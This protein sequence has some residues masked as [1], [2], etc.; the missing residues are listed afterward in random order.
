MGHQVLKGFV[1]LCFW[2][3]HAQADEISDVSMRFHAQWDVGDQERQR[4]QKTYGITRVSFDEKGHA[5]PNGLSPKQLARWMRLYEL[6]MRDG[7]YYC[8]A[9]EGSCEFGTCGPKNTDCKPYIGEK[10]LPQC[11]GQCADYAFISTLT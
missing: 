10:G 1:L 2:L 3:T 11:G 9:N 7:C 6:C 5:I 4:L 8:D